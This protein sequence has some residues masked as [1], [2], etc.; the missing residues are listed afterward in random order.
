MLFLVLREWIENQYNSLENPQYLLGWLLLSIMVFLSLYSLRKKIS[1]LPLGSNRLWYILHLY[2]GF[3]CS[4]I[5]GYHTNWAFPNNLINQVLWICLLIIIIS[6][7]IGFLLIKFLT[8]KISAHGE[9][10]VLNKIPQFISQNREKA[11]YIIKN[12]A[13]TENG[14]P[15]LD[16][17]HKELKS[18]FL[19]K[20]FLWFNLFGHKSRLQQKLDKLNRLQRYL[21]KENIVRINDLNELIKQKYLLTWQYSTLSILRY[22]IILHVPVIWFTLSIIVVHVISQYAF[23]INMPW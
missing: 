23:Q 15:I 5:F 2:A 11:I 22:W 16:F 13:D 3:W 10:M 6:G 14:K 1:T 21:D 9:R 12:A 4:I 19:N 17:Y 20:G 7:Y 8:P 18:I